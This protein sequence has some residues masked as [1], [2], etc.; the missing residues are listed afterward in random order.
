TWTP[1]EDWSLNYSRRQAAREAAEFER[2]VKA[3]EYLTRSERVALEAQRAAEEA[4]I[5]TVKQFGERVFMAAKGPELAE[6]SRASYQSSLNNWIYPTLGDVK[7]IDVTPAMISGLL[8]SMQKQGKSQAT[9]VKIY[10]ILNGL[11][12]MA[13]L[14]DAVPTNPMLKVQRPKKGKNE[15]N[16]AGPEMLTA[17]E[18]NTVFEALEGEPLL[19]QCYVHFLADSGCRRGEVAALCWTDIDWNTGAV[20]IS[21]SLNYTKDKGGYVSTTKNG[22][23]RTVFVGADTLHLLTKLRTAQASSCVSK[24]CF[25]QRNSPELLHPPSP[26]R[27]LK[28]LS[29]RTG[30]NLHP[31]IFRHTFASLAIQSG[32]DVLSVSQVLGHSSTSVT[33][34]VYG[35]ASD[36]AARKAAVI[37]REAAGLK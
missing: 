17:D 20:N 19:W 37:F 23:S 13:F 27:Y 3:G 16:A 2:Q 28:K 8:L 21:K 32:A 31:H 22:H 4:K 1:P 30:L 14:Q 18:L 9:R 36:E 24:Y 5:L 29:A 33:L 26:T 15:E 25:T 35:Y 7:L 12:E 6:N 34:D 10:N 11:F